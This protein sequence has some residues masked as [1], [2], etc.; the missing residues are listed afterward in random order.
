MKEIAQFRSLLDKIRSESQRLSSFDVEAE[1]TE[2]IALV[3]SRQDLVNFLSRY[4]SIAADEKEAIHELAQ[5]EKALL[6]RMEAFKREALDGLRKLDDSKKQRD[7][8]VGNQ[9]FMEGFMF[10][11]RQ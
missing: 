9:N 10:D 2:Y 6:I 4:P 8:Y 5:Y 11:K 1:Y 3:E 7:A